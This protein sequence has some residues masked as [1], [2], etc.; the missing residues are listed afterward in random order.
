M[1]DATPTLLLSM[2]APPYWH[3]GRTVFKRSIDQLIALLPAAAMAVVNWGLPALRV[4]SLAVAVCV[5]VE[6]ICCWAMDRKSTIDDFTAVVAGLLYAFMLP[7]GA[8]WWIVV[9]G[10]V[11]AMLFGKMLFGGHGNNPLSTPLIGWAVLFISFPVHMDP[12]IVQTA[13]SFIDPLARLKY[14]GVAEANAIPVLDLLLG[15]QINALGAGQVGALLLG[16]IYLLVRGQIRWQIV[17]AVLIGAGFPFAYLQMTDP[18]ANASAVFHMCSGSILLCAFFMATEPC[19]APAVSAGMLCY[20]LTCG[21]MMFVIRH[22]GSYSDG[23]PFA[24]LV[25]SL[26]SPYFDMIRPKPFGVK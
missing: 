10:A 25:T 22:F 26:L 23:A 4:M 7:A 21:L 18:A 8:P 15:H 1:K 16:G 17:I 24:V 11:S 5:A 2:S 9:I 14:F 12:N 20:G 3:C 19:T 13:T 6:A